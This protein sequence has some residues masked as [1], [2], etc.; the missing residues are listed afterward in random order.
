MNKKNLFVLTF[1]CIAVIIF[2]LTAATLPV[3]ADNGYY[4]D[5]NGKFVITD[6]NKIPKASDF[7]I[8]YSFP[9]KQYHREIL[10]K[11][12]QRVYD[13]IMTTLQQ[14]N[15]EVICNMEISETEITA[16][17]KSIKRDH[18][19]FFYIN[20]LSYRAMY[21]KDGK[22]IIS[23]AFVYDPAFVKIGIEKAINDVKK[24]AE[25][26]IN[27]A[28]KIENTAD[29]IKYIFEAM[30]DDLTYAPDVKNCLYSQNVYSGIV[31]K[32]SVCAGYSAAFQYYCN[33]LG[34]NCTWLASSYHAWNLVESDGDNYYVD[35]AWGDP[36]NFKIK[37]DYTY[38]NFTDSMTKTLSNRLNRK[39]AYL[40][41]YLS[42]FLPSANGQT[43][44]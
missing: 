12:Q 3:T 33:E 31:T 34:I 19:E 28:K 37:Y 22:Y 29:Q 44:E 13:I 16:V 18:P 17:F 36:N 10:S 41:D 9:T 38:L 39:D 26:I 24:A 40:R 4:F 30:I 42:S 5:K 25:P 23:V 1:F 32:V 6:P 43:K 27:G 15:I 8:A 2:N 20:S 14:G 11:K 21:I 7:N 35:V